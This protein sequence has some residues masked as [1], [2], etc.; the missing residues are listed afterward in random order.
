MPHRL[1]RFFDDLILSHMPLI[2]PSDTPSVVSTLEV[3]S[4]SEKAALLERIEN[5]ERAIR[6]YEKKARLRSHHRDVR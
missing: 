4:K 5:V 1:F 3:L 2:D 6:M